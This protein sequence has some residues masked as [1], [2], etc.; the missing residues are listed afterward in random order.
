MSSITK[1]PRNLIWNS[2]LCPLEFYTGDESDFGDCVLQSVGSIRL[3]ESFGPF[4]IVWISFL[5][6]RW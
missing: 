3:L 2:L 4:P 1:E 5:L 6:F